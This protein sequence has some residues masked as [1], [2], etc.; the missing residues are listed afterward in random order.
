MMERILIKGSVELFK[1]ADR[2]SD[3][4]LRQASIR[5]HIATVN[6]ISHLSRHYSCFFLFLTS[7]TILGDAPAFTLDDGA[8]L[9]VSVMH[10]QQPSE[11]SCRCL[12]CMFRRD[13]HI[14][15]TRRI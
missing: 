7:Y 11:A 2:W 10:T 13:V 1:L 4:P 12:P 8:A 3:S 14:C 15:A 9:S 5:M 6:A